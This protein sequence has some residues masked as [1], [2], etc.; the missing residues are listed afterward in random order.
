MNPRSMS[1]SIRLGP[2]PP[3]GEDLPC[4]DGEPLETKRHRDQMNLLIDSLNEGWRDRHDFFVGGN[5]F[6]YYSETQSKRYDYRGPDVFVVLNTSDRSRKSWVVWEEDGL[7][8]NVIIEL[9]SETTEEIDRGPKM[10]IYGRL[11]RVP[12]YVIY[13]PYS[14]RLDAYRFDLD[15][16]RYEPVVPD[17]RGY[18]RCE[19]L[20]L[21]L[22]VVPGFHRNYREDAPWLR[23]F[24]DEGRMF[25]HPSEVADL[26]RESAAREADRANAAEL[27]VARLRD[28]LERLRG[29]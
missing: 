10:R 19:P 7:A 26:T 23:W 15:H 1:E 6:L 16:D 27:E 14:A 8:P 22:G 28:E 9:T 11:L 2:T 17:A 18:V 4:D 24:D 29:K 12:S 20:G 5:M 3:R 13:D 21:Y 25:L